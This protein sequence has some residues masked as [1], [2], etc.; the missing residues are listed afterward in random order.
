M[1]TKIKT[2][3]LP[4]HYSPANAQDSSYRP[5]ANKLFLSAQ[6]WAKVNGLKPVGGDK[7]KISLLEIDGQFDFSFPQGSLYVAGRSGTSGM[8]VQARLAE[9][10]YKHLGLIHEFIPTMDTHLPY[11]VFFPSAH[12]L[13]DGTHPEPNTPVSSA[14][15]KSKK[16]SANPAMAW[17]IGVDPVWLTKQ[18]TYYCEQLEASDK[19]GLWLWPFHCMLGSEG[20][21]LAGVIEEVR[22]FHSFSRGAENTPE[23]KG[24]NPL[25]ECY[26][27]FR[28]E[29]TMM[30]D[31]RPIPNAQKNA[32]LIERLVKS[33]M[34]IMAGL[35]SSHC[36]KESIADFLGEIK[37]QDPALAKKVYILRDCTAPVVIPG[38]DFTDMAEAALQKFQDEGM[39]V[40]ESTM[41]IE[42][43]PGADSILAGI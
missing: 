18:F 38:V 10:V 32:K 15:Y 36:V 13:E 20:H 35:A 7:I 24:G 27:I 25:T 19:Q 33:D 26:S 1:V 28:P 16:Y 3:G 30:W 14:D 29:V 41:P 4:G 40:V 43:W 9:F 22:Q 2:L 23:I 39:N 8:D 37:A 17:Q 21:R 12:L 11:Q 31:G 34:V 42:S 6:E 5:D